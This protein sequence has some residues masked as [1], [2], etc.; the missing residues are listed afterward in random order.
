MRTGVGTTWTSFRNRFL[1]P[2]RSPWRPTR[3]EDI[4]LT[5]KTKST[6][7]GAFEILINGSAASRAAARSASAA[8]AWKIDVY[9]DAVVVSSVA[10]IRIGPEEK[11]DNGDNDDDS[12]H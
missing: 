10:V 7:S 9:I 3:P 4:I 8:S 2:S 12:D 1:P 5:P 6:L 11:T